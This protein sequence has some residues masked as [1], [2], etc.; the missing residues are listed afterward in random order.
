MLSSNSIPK[1]QKKNKNKS[2]NS[3]YTKNGKNKKIES[4][5][6]GKQCFQYYN[7]NIF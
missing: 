4:N 6:Y 1:N 5:T 3:N 2:S 7:K